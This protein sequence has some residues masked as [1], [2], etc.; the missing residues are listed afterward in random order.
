MGHGGPIGVQDMPY[1]ITNISTTNLNIEGSNLAP[2]QEV[3]IPQVGAALRALAERKAITIKPVASMT[4]I[5][6]G[7]KFKKE[8]L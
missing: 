1:K 3:T 5:T 2:R 8:K 6:S 7:K 4:S